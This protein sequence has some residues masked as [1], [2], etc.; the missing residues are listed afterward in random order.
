MNKAD[1]KRNLEAELLK[2]QKQNKIYGV[3]E[4]RYDL[5]I[6][7]VLNYIENSISKEVIEEKIEKATNEYKYILDNIDRKTSHIKDE[8]KIRETYAEFGI[9]R[10]RLEI[11]EELFK[12]V[13]NNENR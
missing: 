9:K 4:T 12:E 10:G 1:L 2:I 6:K 3:G 8:H 7:D 5:M 13:R 11:L